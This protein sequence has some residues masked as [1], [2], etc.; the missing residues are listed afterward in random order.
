MFGG[1]ARCFIIFQKNHLIRIMPAM[2][3][4]PL[5]SFRSPVKD[6][7]LGT[8]VMVK[9]MG[10]SQGPLIQLNKTRLIIALEHWT[11]DH[12]HC[13]PAGPFPGTAA[14][15]P[16]YFSTKPGHGFVNARPKGDA[17]RGVWTRHRMA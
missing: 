3:A 1:I 10:E 6:F 7:I 14:A 8:P 16:D 4:H 2:H 9:N 11:L 5:L 13:S 15:D 12:S 17:R